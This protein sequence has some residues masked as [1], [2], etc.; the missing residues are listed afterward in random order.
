MSKI[1]YFLTLTLSIL[2]FQHFMKPIQA[3]TLTAGAVNGNITD[4]TGAAVAG[5][6]VSLTS[7][8]KGTVVETVSDSE[9]FYRF[10]EVLPGSYSLVVI[11][12]G[13]RAFSVTGLRVHVQGVLRYDV[14]LEIASIEGDVTI[15]ASTGETINSETP[16]LGEVIEGRRIV[17]LPLNGRNFLQLA[18]LSAGTTPPPTQSGQSTT[19]S[20]TGGRSNLTVSVSGGR[21][22]STSYLFD[23]ISSKHD[24]YGGVG[25]QPAPEAVEEF[26]IQRGFFSPQFSLPGVVNVVTKSGTNEFHGSAWEFV[27]N[28]KFDARNFF[29]VTKPPFR[30]NNYGVAAGGPIIKNKLFL[31]GFYEALKIRRSGTQRL[32]VPLLSQLTGDFRG[33]PTIYDPLTFD[34]VTGARQPFPNNIIPANRISQFARNYLQFI[35]PPTINA[36]VANNLTGQT[37]LIED[38]NKYMIRGDYTRSQSS[39]FLVRYSH[40]DLDQ[41]T[42]SPLPFRNQIAPLR[43]RNAVVAWTYTISPNLVNDLRAGLDRVF[44]HSFAPENAATNPNFAKELGLQNTNEIADCNGVPFVGLAGFAAFGSLSVCAIT[45]NS[46]IHLLD[47]V[48]YNR[49]KHFITGGFEIRRI[50]F[51]NVGASSPNGNLGFNGQYTNSGDRAKGLGT[52]GSPVADFLLGFPS[53][54]TAQVSR[55]PFYF[56]G[57]WW[58]IYINDD[59]KVSRDLTLNFGLRYQYTQPLVEKYDRVMQIDFTTGQLRLAAQ[60]GNP[61]SFLTPDRNDFAPRVGMAWRPTK[62]DSWA[63]R[64]SYGIFY[65]RL[66]GNEWNFQSNNPPF[67]G[68]FDRIADQL[69]PN[70]NI[71][72][73]F[74]LITLDPTGASFFNLADRRSPYLEQWTVSSQNILPGGIF[75]EAAYVGS[76]GHNLSK[77]LNRNAALAPP[78]PGDTRPL[79]ARRPFPQY[80]NINSDE[81]IAKS[82]Y[83]GMQLTTRKITSWGLNLLAGYTWSKSLDMDSY[84]AAGARN[85]RP[86][87]L[88]YGRSIF[89]IRHRFVSSMIY[90]LP[91][92]KSSRGVTKQLLAGWQISSIVALQTGY[93]FHV[94]TTVDASN[95][96]ANLN[97]RPNRICDGNLPS[98]Q[99]TVERWFDTSCFVLPAQNTYGNAGVNYLDTDGFR[100]VDLAVLKNFNFSENTRIQLR[101]EAFNL[102]NNVSFGPP[103]NF[104]GTLTF[105]RVTTA[106]SARELQFGVKVT[107]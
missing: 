78:A 11:Q 104:L 35:P 66:P 45:G 99:Q 6:Q 43:S 51:R 105:G 90:D 71:S 67:A 47:N 23:G 37:K 84:D 102:F 53:S 9:G 3:Q 20:L 19:S 5:A 65:D 39:R 14:T 38:D 56:T 88:D 63:L 25:S 29:D 16:L 62:S 18:Q 10:S 101:A 15:S 17:D 2:A 70:I 26:K 107:W 59:Y 64:A 49:G 92:G 94:I 106:L 24:F 68:R 85:Y 55:S 95:T 93:P 76:R 87:D 69:V 28:D 60:N 91:F 27:R 12:S 21:E 50:Y 48:S 41:T 97:P 80:S 86:G 30:Q 96:G 98:S 40:D 46:N 54:A 33:L 22:I 82:S 100:R 74:P 31:F 57:Y 77:R 79:Q 42:T 83:H 103:G 72:T 34:P 7:V 75:F 8:D 1:L 52:G 58:D 36:L 73:L 32:T 81:G 4:E 44:V 13:F 61:R 89:D